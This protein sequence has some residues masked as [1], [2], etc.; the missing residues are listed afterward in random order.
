MIPPK[1]NDV[2]P[3]T[4]LAKGLKE[5]VVPLPGPV[6]LAE[7]F[8]EPGAVVKGELNPPVWEGK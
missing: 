5:A 6:K 7:T 4:P 8:V 3:L 1:R 2:T